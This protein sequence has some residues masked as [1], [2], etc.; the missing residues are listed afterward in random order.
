MKRSARLKDVAREVGLSVSAVSYALRGARNIPEATRERVRAVAAKLGYRPQPR[1]GE[2]MAHIRRG[3][4]L[5]A[6]EWLAFLWMDA[7][8]KTRTFAALGDGARGRAR[9]LGYGLDEFW[10]SEPGMS[11]ARLEGILRARGIRGVL[12]SPLMGPGPFHLPWA[13]ESFSGV[14]L[15]NAAGT[16]ELHRAG[17][18]HF[19]GMRQ[20]LQRLSGQGMRRIAGLIDARVNE[21]AKRAWSAAFLEHHPQPLQARRLLKMTEAPRRSEV[22]TWWSRL[23]PEALVTVQGYLTLLP[24]AARRQTVVLD[25][26]A[27]LVDC[28]GIDQMEDRIAAQAVDLLVAQL[29]RNEQGVPERGLQLLLPGWWR[30]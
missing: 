8:W 6:G 29:Q 14:I 17:H 4:T 12:L 13:W 20:A 28:P 11:P 21:R 23:R 26:K 22:G 27:G 3:K 16:P 2:L 9:E 15:G 18:H 25:W 1:V 19:D 30:E 10:L 24:A 5:L 7:P